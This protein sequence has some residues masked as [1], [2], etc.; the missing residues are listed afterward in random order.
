M[1]A[2]TTATLIRLLLLLL[3]SPRRR[4]TRVATR[5]RLGRGWPVS[6]Q[7]AELL[8]HPERV[9]LRPLLGDPAPGQA[10]DR[11][12]RHRDAASGRGQAA[13]VGAVGA[14]RRQPDGDAVAL[15]DLVFDD[16]LEVREGR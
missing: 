3:V 12:L 11:V 9:D 13:E 4:S 15:G 8:H 5:R 2:P 7:G 14:A 1:P 10:E 6:G 16:V